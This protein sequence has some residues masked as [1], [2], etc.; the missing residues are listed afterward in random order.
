MLAAE[1]RL[2]LLSLKNQRVLEVQMRL[3]VFLPSFESPVVLIMWYRVQE[4]SEYSAGG[5]NLCVCHSELVYSDNM[6]R[7]MAAEG[8]RLLCKN[9]YDLIFII[10]LH[11]MPVF[12]SSESASVHPS[13]LIFR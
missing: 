6:T 3:A 1:S 8:V 12:S 9:L 2:S 13:I 10:L 7:F 11:H 4:P 5:A